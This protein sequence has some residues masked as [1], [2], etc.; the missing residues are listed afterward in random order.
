MNKVNND[1]D[2]HRVSL[3][4]EVLEVVRRSRPRRHGKEAR[5][6]ITEAAVVGMLLD[7]HELDHVV[8]RLLDLGQDLVSVESV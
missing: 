7:S 1:L 2:A 5:H 3:V 6:M 8:A 4:H